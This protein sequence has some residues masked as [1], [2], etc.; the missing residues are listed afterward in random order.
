MKTK[1]TLL[2]LA[3]GLG[4]LTSANVFAIDPMS[5][6]TDKAV[7]KTEMIVEKDIE[8]QDWMVKSA[9]F[10]TM[11]AVGSEK[12]LGLEIWMIDGSWNNK[13]STVT[14]EAELKVE[15]WMLKSKDWMLNFS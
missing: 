2:T 12:S 4:I 1:K 11:D 7:S 6:S 9:L 15:D 10:K 13:E 8:V 5:F 3:L 14:P